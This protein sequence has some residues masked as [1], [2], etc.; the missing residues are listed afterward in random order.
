MSDWYL[1]RQLENYKAQIRGGHDDDIYGDQMF[2]MAS[3]LKNEQS[4][5]NVIAYINSLD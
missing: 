3:S 2:M 1:K 4:V 5:D